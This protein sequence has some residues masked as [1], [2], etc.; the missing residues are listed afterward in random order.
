MEQID[1]LN[2]NDNNDV[3]TNI[4]LSKKELRVETKVNFKE[5]RKNYKME[6]K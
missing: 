5:A 6:Y 4:E 2:M 3:F 1:I